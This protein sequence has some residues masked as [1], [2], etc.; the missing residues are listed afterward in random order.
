M[1]FLIVII[2]MITISEAVI[3]VIYHNINKLN[4]DKNNEDDDMENNMGAMG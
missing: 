3:R 1:M 2:L 4:D